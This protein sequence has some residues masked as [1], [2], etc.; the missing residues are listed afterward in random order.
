MGFRGKADFS[1]WT[2]G[3]NISNLLIRYAF[4][5]GEIPIKTSEQEFLT[6]MLKMQKKLPIDLHFI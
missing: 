6:L 3:L 1:E 2:K 4:P 5:R